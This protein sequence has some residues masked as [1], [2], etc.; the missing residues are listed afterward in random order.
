MKL[1]K[2]QFI[3]SSSIEP[4]FRISYENVHLSYSIISITLDDYQNKCLPHDLPF[5][6]SCLNYV[7]KTYI[8]KEV[9][10]NES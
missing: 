3:T 8:K 4:H 9:K 5:F 7:L 2:R 10:A 1:E 6:I